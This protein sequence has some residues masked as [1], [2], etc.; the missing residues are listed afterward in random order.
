MDEIFLLDFQIAHLT[1]SLAAAS[2]CQLY[3]VANLAEP[4]S[5]RRN[6]Q[7]RPS[8]CGCDFRR[9]DLRTRLTIAADGSGWLD[10]EVG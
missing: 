8:T 2:K 9:S 3:K 5:M 7:A 10:G 6:I 4:W 1:H